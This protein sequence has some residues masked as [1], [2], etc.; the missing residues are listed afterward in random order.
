MVQSMAKYPNAQAIRAARAYT[1]DEAASALRINEVTIRAWIKCGLPAMTTNRPFLILGEDLRNFVQDRRAKAKAN[2]AS[3]ELLCMTCKA[4][5]KPFGML[6]DLH[7]Q[8][9]KTARLV[10]LCEVCGGTCSRMISQTKLGHF[11][12]IFDLGTNA[13]LQ[14]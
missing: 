11:G 9:G 13:G 3:D 14:A 1:I 5:R 7:L 10:G 4:A 6:V 12:G 2:L 8:N